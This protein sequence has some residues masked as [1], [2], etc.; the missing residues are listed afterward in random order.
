MV[1]MLW[2]NFRVIGDTAVN[3]D[4]IFPSTNFGALGKEAVDIKALTCGQDNVYLSYYP[5][6]TYV[7]WFMELRSASRY[8]YMW[9]W[10]AEVA[11]K[12]AFV[13]I[14]SHP[15]VIVVMQDTVVWVKYDTKVYL[16]PFE[17]EL[18]EQ[19][20]HIKPD[21]YISPALAKR[22]KTKP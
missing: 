7:Y 14:S 5:G 9:P 15:F 17:Q 21:I 18:I 20:I 22:C 12:K 4:K 10:V 3:L 8:L 1:S 16:H 6:G 11:Q 2:L 19:F 13:E